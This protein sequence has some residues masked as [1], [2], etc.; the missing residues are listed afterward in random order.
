MLAERQRLSFS[1]FPP[2]IFILCLSFVRVF[3]F[4]FPCLSVLCCASWFVKWLLQRKR[5]WTHW[6]GLVWSVSSWNVKRPAWNVDGLEVDSPSPDGLN[7]LARNCLT[8]R[9]Q[10]GQDTACRIQ[11]T[12]SLR[13]CLAA[14]EQLGQD[15]ACRQG[16][17]V[18]LV[19]D[20][21]CK[22][23]YS[24]RLTTRVQLD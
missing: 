6:K 4:A 8:A 10:L 15:T 7:H 20:T 16:Y 21:A 19:W 2:G 24:T 9:E 18:Q 12:A 17:R 13:H 23:G 3:F 14:G 11:A 22:P 5:N 1:F